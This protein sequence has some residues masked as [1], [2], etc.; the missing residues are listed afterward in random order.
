[1]YELLNTFSTNETIRFQ[2][3]QRCSFSA[4]VIENYIAACIEHR[5]P[6]DSHHH[7]HHNSHGPS[8]R[9]A[10]T[11]TGPNDQDAQQ[12]IFVPP[13][14]VSRLEEYVSTP[15]QASEIG[16]IV[17]T[18]AK[19]YAQR[20]IAEAAGLQK[21]DI[22]WTQQQQQTTSNNTAATSSAMDISGSPNSTTNGSS[23][24]NHHDPSPTIPHIESI[25]N[26]VLLCTYVYKTIEDR[27]RRNIDPGFFVTPP[28]SSTNNNN[29]YNV[30]QTTSNLIYDQKRLA[31]MAAVA[32]AEVSEGNRE[33][34]D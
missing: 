23:N 13:P 15:A 32:S 28:S 31:T 21:K 1:M 11:T 17:A 9:T 5:S 25:N 30:H 24:N 20:L 26:H 6:H 4:S 33:I 18:A 2:S 3:H 22:R 27:Q 12:S 10:A 34:K 7:R 8:D 14:S 19:I 16:M 29:N